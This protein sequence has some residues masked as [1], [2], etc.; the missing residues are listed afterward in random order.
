MMGLTFFFFLWVYFY[1]KE[2]ECCEIRTYTKTGTDRNTLCAWWR[3]MYSDDLEMQSLWECVCT[4]HVTLEDQSCPPTKRTDLVSRGCGRELTENLLSGNHAAALFYYTTTEERGVTL[5]VLGT[6]LVD[7]KNRKNNIFLRDTSSADDLL[8]AHLRRA[9]YCV[10]HDSDTSYRR[11]HRECDVSLFCPA[12]TAYNLSRAVLRITDSGTEHFL[13][14][15][16]YIEEIADGCRGDRERSLMDEVD[17]AARLQDWPSADALGC[18]RYAGMRWLRWRKQSE[19]SEIDFFYGAVCVAAHMCA[20]DALLAAHI[21]R[22]LYV[23]CVYCYQRKFPLEIDVRRMIG[24]EE[25]NSSGECVA[26]SSFDEE[27]RQAIN[28][29]HLAHAPHLPLPKQV[30]S[31]PFHEVLGLVE[32]RRVP[33]VRGRALITYTYVAVWAHQRWDSEV[34]RIQRHD[35]AHILTPLRLCHKQRRER[36]LGPLPTQRRFESTVNY[37]ERLAPALLRLWGDFEERLQWVSF[38]R[39]GALPFKGRWHTEMDMHRELFMPAIEWWRKRRRL[40]TRRLGA[41]TY[42]QESDRP[43]G[44]ALRRMRKQPS[45]DVLRDFG[46]VFPPCVLG[47]AES[48]VHLK[49]AQRV[50]LFRY[51]AHMGVPLVGAQQLWFDIC[52]RDPGVSVRQQSSEEFARFNTEYGQYPANLYATQ[53]LKVEKSPTYRGGFMSCKTVQADYAGCCPYVEDIED[54]VMRTLDCGECMWSRQ[55]EEKKRAETC[56][57]PTDFWGPRVATLKAVNRIAYTHHGQRAVK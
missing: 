32:E 26:I 51:L 29:A 43:L 6:F 54:F 25:H 44:T 7:L 9:P 31:V 55:P 53:Q 23:W 4:I 20:R 22:G 1:S 49:D 14:A 38:V 5:A 35:A 10:F 39:P 50:F 33:L 57:W 11:D 19:S 37:K 15:M 13:E 34:Q 56:V 46:A 17:A 47:L 52:G 18:S 16:L 45:G 30:Y 27:T 40:L 21:S 48:S 28:A 12:P 3:E 41:I 42:A 36:Q 24:L 8:M 2:Q